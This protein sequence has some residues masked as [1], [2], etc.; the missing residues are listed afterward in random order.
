[1]TDTKTEVKKGG[2]VEALFNVGA[3]LGY[4][5]ARRHASM[6]N[7]I[8]GNKGK[9]DIIDLAESARLLE[10][11]LEFVRSLGASGK[12]VL[13][14]G[15]KPEVRDIV[16]SAA[17]S[18]SM[19]YVAGRWIGGTLTNFS[20]IKKRIKRL[21]DLSSDRDAG[22]LAKKY[23]KKERVLID[24]EIA[25]LE[26]NFGGLAGME[27]LPHALLVVDTRAEAIAVKEANDLGIPVV[28]IMNSDCDLSKVQHPI[29]GNDAARTSVRFFI[30]EAVRSFRAG[31]SGAV[32]KS[33]IIN[34]QP[35]TAGNTSPA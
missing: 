21:A 23:T 5:R 13:F 3:H 18:L 14:V 9:T 22:T 12:M 2:L 26:E 10:E 31:A 24:R 27:N 15:G 25:R 35:K 29:I 1:M 28:G 4:S 6:K 16:R 11:S 20:E 8:F 32:A 30:D 7:M 19:P 33:E 17:E 34:T